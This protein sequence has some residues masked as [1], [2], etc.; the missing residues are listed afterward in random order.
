MS[1]VYREQRFNGLKFDHYPTPHH[2]I[3]TTESNSLTLVKD[4][5]LL[6]TGT[7]YATQAQLMRKGFF[8]NSL[9]QTR[10]QMTMNLNS[11]INSDCGKHFSLVSPIPP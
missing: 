9:T 5:N 1:F 6:L 3:K 11:R 8:I 7:P 10:P 2:Q 4:G